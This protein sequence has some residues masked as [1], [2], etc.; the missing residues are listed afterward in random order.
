[1]A[2]VLQNPEYTASLAA[3]REARVRLMCALEALKRAKILVTEAKSRLQASKEA[4]APALP[5]SP[6][7][8]S[9]WDPSAATASKVPR[10]TTD[11]GMAG[12]TNEVAAEDALR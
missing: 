8:I 2:N 3:V 1:M 7:P 9:L 12:A 6:T 11:D 4:S 5:P 10:K